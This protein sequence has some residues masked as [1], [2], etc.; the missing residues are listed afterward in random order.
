MTLTSIC[1]LEVA[2]GAVGY[3]HRTRHRDKAVTGFGTYI[4]FP[5]IVAVFVALF[6]LNQSVP[7]SRERPRILDMDHDV[8]FLSVTGQLESL[9]HMQLFGVRRTEPV[10]RTF[11]IE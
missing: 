3:G 4:L 9:D 8:E 1:H 5:V 2:F 7:G 6:E 11:I 10:E